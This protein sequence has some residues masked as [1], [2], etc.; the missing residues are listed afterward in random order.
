MYYIAIVVDISNP[1]PAVLAQPKNGFMFYVFAPSSQH[2]PTD[3]VADYDDA[4]A[5]RVARLLRSDFNR[6]VASFASS[7]HTTYTIEL[8]YR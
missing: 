5:M 4:S 2:I 1:S 7:Q 8:Y 6:S 3:D